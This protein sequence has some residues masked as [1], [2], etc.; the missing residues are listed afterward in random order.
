MLAAVNWGNAPDREAATWAHA[1]L[2]TASLTAR[3]EESADD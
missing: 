3:K 2:V 1:Q